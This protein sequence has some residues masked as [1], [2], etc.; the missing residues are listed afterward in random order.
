MWED[1][2][3][4]TTALSNSTATHFF[5][6][7]FG[8]P[9][10]G[11]FFLHSRFTSLPSRW[12][13]M[14]LH[15]KQLMLLLLHNLKLTWDHEVLTHSFPSISTQPTPEAFRDLNW[16]KTIH[17]SKLFS[18]ALTGRMSPSRALLQPVLAPESCSPRFSELVYSTAL[19]LLQ[20]KC[21]HSKLWHSHM[22]KGTEISCSQF[23]NPKNHILQL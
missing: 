15:S 8:L 5:P 2:C 20:E 13:R 1:R 7:K 17:I 14:W 19:Q 21:G 6:G 4:I 16:Q 23:Y 18:A 10:R 9:W 3:F 22:N 12:D 11:T